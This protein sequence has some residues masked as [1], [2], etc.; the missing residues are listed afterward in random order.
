MIGQAKRLYEL[1]KVI[2]NSARVNRDVPVIAFTSGKGGTGKSF[3][4]LNLAYLLSTQNYRVLVV[5]FDLN[6]ANLH[7]LLNV[8]PE[9]TYYE[10]FNSGAEV[11][12]LISQYNSNLHFLFGYSGKEENAIDLV[13]VRNLLSEINSVS[14]Q[15][16]FIF[17]DTSSGGGDLTVEI[18]SQ[19]DQ[20]MIITNPEPTSVMDAYAI[21]KLLNDRNNKLILQ[22]VVNKA[23]KKED[24]D[25]AYNNL[26]VALQHFLKIHVDY[27]GFIPFEMEAIKAALNQTM[28]VKQLP[29][30]EAVKSLTQ[31][32][33]RLIKIKQV[34]N[35]NHL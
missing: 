15:Y 21:I 33:Q 12:N 22:L 23:L 8:M 34:A 20:L 27:F 6:F 1:Q 18:L 25:F 7:T 13:S 4:C 9:K 2:R 5:D 26:N 29:E 3:V 31:F 11:S 32:S 16:D 24:A 30:V 28:L 10:Y 14:S 17:F 35:I 19:A